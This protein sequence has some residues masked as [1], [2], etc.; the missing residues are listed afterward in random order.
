[1]IF[2]LDNDDV[3]FPDPRL[4]PVNKRERSGLYAIGGDLRP[5]RLIAAYSL[6]IF[7][8]TAFED[9]EVPEGEEPS[10]WNQYRWYCPVKRFVIFPKE[11]HISHSMRTLLNKNKY[12]VTLDK[13]FRGVIGGCSELR[14]DEE[15]AWLGPQMVEAYTRLH[16]MGVAHS[17]EVWDGDRLVGGLYGVFLNGVFM[18]ESMFSLVPSASKIA[19]IGL[20]QMMEKIGGK[21]IDCQLETPHLCSM[22]GR[23]ISYKEYMQLLERDWS[24]EPKMS[25]R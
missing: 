10:V 9:L 14:I 19:L 22:G 16:D 23:H 1:M 3:F 6:G 20:A 25:E 18:G 5:E 21:F 15:G 12:R 13:D 4:V 17:V 24:D 7:P 11:I 2:A 8:W